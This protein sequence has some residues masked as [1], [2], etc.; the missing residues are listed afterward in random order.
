L[1]GCGAETSLLIQSPWLMISA[2]TLKRPIAPHLE[3]KCGAPHSIRTKSAALFPS[4]GR[5]PKMRLHQHHP[6]DLQASAP[7]ISQGFRRL[8]ETITVNAIENR[9]A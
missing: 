1:S 9:V 7:I 3:R 2:S 5:E 8:Y 6:W 4:A